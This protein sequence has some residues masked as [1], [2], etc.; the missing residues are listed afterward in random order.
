MQKGFVAPPETVSA[1][2]AFFK[3]LDGEKAVVTI[4][5]EPVQYRKHWDNATGRSEMCGKEETG[6]CHICDDE[7]LSQEQRF[8]GTK[9]GVPIF[10]HALYPK[11]NAK[12]VE[13][14]EVR[15]WE[16][17]ASVLRALVAIVQ[18]FETPDEWKTASLTIVRD[19]SGL[20]TKYQIIP[21]KRSF[22][23]PAGVEV[24]NLEEYYAS[25][26]GRGPVFNNDDAIGDPFAEE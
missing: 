16:N 18:T 13:V 24:P 14:K 9:F 7:R 3:L 8:A 23:V 17:G 10:V 11:G 4:L 26:L 25:K 12:P 15:I 2:A 22:P 5:D 6:A 21:M 1:G 20:T 19:G